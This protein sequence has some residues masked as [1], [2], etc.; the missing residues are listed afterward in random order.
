MYNYTTVFDNT[1]STCI[2]STSLNEYG[3]NCINMLYNVAL[4]LL[5]TIN[6]TQA[7]QGLK[8]IASPIFKVPLVLQSSLLMAGGSITAVIVTPQIFKLYAEKSARGTSWGMTFLNI[9]ASIIS[10][11]YCLMAVKINN[12]SWTDEMISIATIAFSIFKTGAAISL[13]GMKIYY[14]NHYLL[15]RIEKISQLLKDF[16]T[17]NQKRSIFCSKNNESKDSESNALTDKSNLQELINKI[18]KNIT[19]GTQVSAM[20]QEDVEALMEIFLVLEES[21]NEQSDYQKQISKNIKNI[22]I[23]LL[24]S[25][26]HYKNAKNEIKELVENAKKIKIL[27]PHI[28]ADRGYFKKRFKK[29]EKLEEILNKIEEFSRKKNERRKNHFSPAKKF[30]K[31]LM[32]CFFDKELNELNEDL[33]NKMIEINHLRRDFKE[34]LKCLKKKHFEKLSEQEKIEFHSIYSLFFTKEVES[35]LKNNTVSLID[36]KSVNE[37]KSYMQNSNTENAEN[38]RA[39]INQFLEKIGNIDLLSESNNNLLTNE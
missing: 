35:S 6:A 22:I 19:S 38:L 21:N 29:I 13:V 17:S 18:K 2:N 37:L 1:N 31:D 36:V 34:D 11:L 20:K 33:S 30:A 26:K 23:E 24:I 27:F 28:D 12:Q 32:P 3:E 15:G 9:T 7:I 8:N 14:D 25:G 39:K 10:N 5:S 4:C 16:N